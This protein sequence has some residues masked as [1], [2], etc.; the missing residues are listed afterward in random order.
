MCGIAGA[1]S[2]EG[3]DPLLS[4]RMFRVID[5]RGPDGEGF[6]DEPHASLGMRRLA[7]I[8]IATGDQPVY[9]EAGSVVA[10]FNGEVHNFA[11]LRAELEGRGHRF[12]TRTDSECLVH[13]YERYS[14]NLVRHLRGMFAFAVWDSRRCRLVLG[15][16]RFGKKPQY[17]GTN[18]KGLQFASEL[19]SLTQAAEMPPRPDLVALRH[20]LTFGYIPA[21]WSIYQGVSKL[22]PGHVLIWPDGTAVLRRCWR[23]DFTPRPTT[24]EHEEADRLRALLLEATRTR[25]VSDRPLGAFLSGGIGS[26]AVVAAMAILSPG[27]VMTFSVGFAEPSF[28][29]RGYARALARHDNT[30]HHE[31]VLTPSVGEFLPSLAWHF[32]EPF[33]D[34]SALPTFCLARMSG[35]HVT[36]VLT[37]D[38]G[39]E[40]FGGYRRYA[41][42]RRAGRLALPR[43]AGTCR[44]RLGDRLAAHSRPRSR[45]R[46]VPRVLQ[47]L[48]H[49]VN[50]RYRRIVSCFTAEQKRA[51]YTDALRG[52]IAV[53]SEGLLA[54]AWRSCTATGTVGQLMEVDLATMAHALEARSPLLDHH[55][56]EWAAAL[57]DEL[58]VRGGQ[59]KYLLRKAVEPWLPAR[60]LHRPKVGFGVPLADWLRGELRDFAH[61]LLTD[62]ASVARGLFRPQAVGALLREHQADHDH[63]D[64]IWALTQMERWHRHFGAD[65]ALPSNRPLCQG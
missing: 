25:M 34:S 19:K 58:R 36:M 43:P 4:G 40:M 62:A 23:L 61:D 16:D 2:A 17:Y 39:D 11:E 31:V 38:G 22:P 24:G 30:D 49:P 47:L 42:M 5:H 13:L 1:V 60:F 46:D 37:G 20:Y 54:E 29:E 10:V 65:Q 35:K 48:A 41:L 9:N 6:H 14:E 15:R 27:R 57:P 59:T 45:P 12:T 18:G 3:A 50:R 64:R 52:Q 53:D 28:D 7:V 33:A 21:P 44:G 32:D 55:L 56:A 63:A 8:D 26:S 51:L